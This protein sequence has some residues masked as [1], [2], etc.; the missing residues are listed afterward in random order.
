MQEV[1]ESGAW[2]EIPYDD[3]WWPFEARFGFRASV[4]AAG[5]PAIDEPHGA[6]TLDLA[7][8]FD[9][10]PAPFAAG[11]AAVDAVALR[12]FVDLLGQDGLEGG[13][14]ELVALDWQ[15][16]AYRWSPARHAL[17]GG[18]WR[19]PVVPDGDYRAHVHP[20]QVWGTFGHPWQRTLTVWGEP[21]VATLGA[22]LAAWLPV[23]R[24][25]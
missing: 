8:V 2:R 25:A 17:G 22:E 7:P 16:P 9:A 20:D 5:P 11:S 18:T 14:G 13:D 15:H 21:L 6:V 10:G 1:G 23:R 19:V 24:R 3:A 12:A 4:D